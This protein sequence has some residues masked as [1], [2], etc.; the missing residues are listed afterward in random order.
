MR[1][2]RWWGT[3]GRCFS[4]GYIVPRR[5]GVGECRWC[6]ATHLHCFPPCYFPI[7]TSC[8]S[9]IKYKWWFISF[10]TL[11]SGEYMPL[12]DF[13]GICCCGCLRRWGFGRRNQIQ[14]ICSF[15]TV[16]N[17]GSCIKKWRCLNDGRL[18]V[19]RTVDPSSDAFARTFSVIWD[20]W[21]QIICRW[22]FERL[23]KLP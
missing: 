12:P 1:W 17:W 21:S 7:F 14:R 11:P 16:G 15:C 22:F 4:R 13:D 18:S 2:W 9:S 8:K 6:T 20:T 5:S 3:F 10:I 23:L 19:M